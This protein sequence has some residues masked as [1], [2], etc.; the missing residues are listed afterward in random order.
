[1][2]TRPCELKVCEPLGLVP[3]DGYKLIRHSGQLSIQRQVNC[4]MDKAVTLSVILMLVG[5]ITCGYTVARLE[6]LT[7][8]WVAAG[9]GSSGRVV[10]A[11]GLE[12]G[13]RPAGGDGVMEILLHADRL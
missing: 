2:P 11:A 6:E 4:G 7:C 10:V 8:R 9:S 5:R 13:A 12:G 3:S 1:M